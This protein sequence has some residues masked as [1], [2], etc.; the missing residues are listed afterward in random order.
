MHCLL[1]RLLA[2]AGRQRT[3]AQYAR[4]EGD[5]GAGFKRARARGGGGAGG[6]GSSVVEVCMGLVTGAV[7]VGGP[8][9]VCDPASGGRLG[10]LEHGEGEEEEVER[11]WDP[12]SWGEAPNISLNQNLN[13]KPKPLRAWDPC[14]WGEAQGVYV[15]R[16]AFHILENCEQQ[17]Y[18]PLHHIHPPPHT[19][20]AFHIL[21][22]GGRG[23]ELRGAGGWRGRKGGQGVADGFWKLWESVA[24]L[25]LRR[26]AGGRMCVCA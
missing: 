24:M 26:A 7:G 17:M 15:P 6:E 4:A 12:C 14:S 21:A 11:A 10:G 13:P 19:P 25:P 22:H 3:T 1:L 23:E 2:S 5:G 8:V 20:L 9:L 16:L 18:P